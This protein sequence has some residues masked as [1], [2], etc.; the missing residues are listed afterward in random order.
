M[1]SPT[2]RKASASR[3]DS[4]GDM[5]YQPFSGWCVRSF[6]RSGLASKPLRRTLNFLCGLSTYITTVFGLGGGR[7]GR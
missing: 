1:Y 6:D 5:M 3:A 4:I 7:G 2:G